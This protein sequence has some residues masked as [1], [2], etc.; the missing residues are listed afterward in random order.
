MKQTIIY[1][2]TSTELQNPE[3]QLDNCRELANKLSLNDYE[4]LQ[5]K[6]SA[7]KDNIERESF[8]K[9]REAIKKQEIKTLICWDLDR[10]YRNRKKLIAF[11]EFCKLYNCKI[12][13]ARQDW[14]ESL[15]KMPEP[16]NEIMHNL[17]L[18]IMGWLAEDDSKKK[19]MRVKNAVRREE[20]VT[21]SYKGNKWGRR[22][23]E[24]TRLKEEVLKLRGQGLTL[25]Q[26]AKQVYYY[27]KNN[28]KKNPSPAL[29]LKLL[30]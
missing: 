6:Q 21:K 28:N 4:V 11:F 13:S 3:N 1:I 5:D 20:G 2:R 30:N 23:I 9:I 7:W 16:F 14:L 27:D 26:I 18:Q 8:E 15:N 25:R 22:S 12:Y 29:I 24:T 19:S 10:L 17:M